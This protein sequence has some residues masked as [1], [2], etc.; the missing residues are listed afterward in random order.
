M[1]LFDEAVLKESGK[2]GGGSGRADGEAV[3]LVLVHDE[4]TVLSNDVS[5]AVQLPCAGTGK[6]RLDRQ[7]ALQIRGAE[8]PRGPGQKG[9]DGTRKNRRRAG[10]RESWQFVSLTA[11]D[12]L[13]NAG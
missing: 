1:Y 10:I 13:S 9:V 4:I 2:R 3:R 5:A 12:S 11:E 8:T 7:R 6:D